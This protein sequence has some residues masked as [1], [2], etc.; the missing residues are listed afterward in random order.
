M[1]SRNSAL[2]ICACLS[3]TCSTGASNFDLSLV[4]WSFSIFSLFFSAFC[5]LRQIFL[6]RFSLYFCPW[7]L[8]IRMLFDLLSANWALSLSRSNFS[9]KVMSLG[10]GDKN[11]RGLGL[12][13]ASR[14][15]GLARGLGPGLAAALDD[16]VSITSVMK[17]LAPAGSGSLML[18]N[19]VPEFLVVLGWVDLIALYASISEFFL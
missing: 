16:L 6:S 10:D 13:L 14:L 19:I 2:A 8:S 4:N 3:C 15:L 7:K 18:G 11:L 17:K 5:N 9:S 12:W 1:V